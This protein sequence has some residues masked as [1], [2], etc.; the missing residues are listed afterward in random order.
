MCIYWHWNCGCTT[1]IWL[2]TAG[3]CWPLSAAQTLKDRI[4]IIF[5]PLNFDFCEVLLTSV[6][7]IIHIGLAISNQYSSHWKRIQFQ[8]WAFN[9]VSNSL[10]NSINQCLTNYLT[11]VSF[12]FIENFTLGRLTQDQHLLLGMGWHVSFYKYNSA[13]A[14]WR[15]K[16]LWLLCISRKSRGGRSESESMHCNGRWSCLWKTCR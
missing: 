10:S 16:W 2:W 8:F 15:A 12:C 11:F 1:F 14:S 4:F 6:C 13:M 9:Q 5:I 3:R 7:F